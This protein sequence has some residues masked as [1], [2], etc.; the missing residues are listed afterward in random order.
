MD[1]EAPGS[2]KDDDL[3]CLAAAASDTFLAEDSIF[4]QNEESTI[5]Q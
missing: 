3:G 4:K 5:M 1:F 2:Q